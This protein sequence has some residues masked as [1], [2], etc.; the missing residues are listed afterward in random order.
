M[1]APNPFPN[2][3]GGYSTIAP[4]GQTDSTG[5]YQVQ[6]IPAGTYK[7]FFSPTTNHLT[8]WFN[9]KG[10]F[11][12]SDPVTVTANQTTPN[13]NAQL[14]PGGI[15]SGQV[16]SI[17]GNGIQNVEVSIYDLNNNFIKVTGTD[18]NGNYQVQGIPTGN[19]KVYFFPLS[20]TNYIFQWNNNK[21]SFDTADS[22]S[23]TVNQTTNI[24]AQLA[25]GGI[26]SGQV[27]SIPGNPIQ[28]VGV[29]IYDSNTNAFVKGIGTDSNGNYLIKG[30][31]AGNYNVYFSPPSSTN[32]IFQWYTADP[33]TVTVSLTTTN[34]NAQLAFGGNISGQVTDT[35]GNGISNV[36]VNVNDAATHTLVGFGLTDSNGNYI[37]QGLPATL[38]DGTNYN[39]Q[40]DPTGAG[41]Y[42]L[43]WYDHKPDFSQA[44]P[45]LVT[46]N[47]TTPLINATLAKPP[48][49]GA[50]TNKRQTSG[51]MAIQLNGTVNPD[52]LSTAYSFEWGPT[53]AYENTPTSSQSAGNGTSDV[54]V[55]ADLSGLPLNRIY[56]YRIVST[57]SIGTLRGSDMIFNTAISK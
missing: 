54:S 7:V 31:P 33:V 57:N 28:N 39:I 56:H 8:Q 32:Y 35:S 29:N 45:V 36:L 17:P 53:T 21:N 16:T 18:S 43:E 20:T 23:V 38:T 49:T 19:Y 14:A 26:I 1:E 3:T 44:N 11:A 46:L 2:L 50:A 52:G 42:V 9:N 25:P 47:Q 4:I 41:N 55:S 30:I 6:G 37:T 13:I 27:T 51:T 34:I 15:I 40:F 12:A 24:N 5:N 10:G 48:T 22:V